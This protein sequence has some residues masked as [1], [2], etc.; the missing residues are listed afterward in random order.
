[1]RP[2]RIIDSEFAI[3]AG[4]ISDAADLLLMIHELAEFENEKGQVNS[5]RSACVACSL[6][7]LIKPAP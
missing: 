7:A 2:A 4:R 5:R 6:A 1:M 3:R